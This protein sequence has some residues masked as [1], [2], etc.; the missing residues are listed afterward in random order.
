MAHRISRRFPIA[1]RH[2]EQ[3]ASEQRNDISDPQRQVD[4]PEGH[5]DIA[6]KD[7]EQSAQKEKDRGIEREENA[8]GAK[9][10]RDGV[11]HDGRMGSDNILRGEGS[12]LQAPRSKHQRSSKHRSSR[13][14][15][16]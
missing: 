6:R 14:Q 2:G 4:K 11:W 13:E 3:D 5:L 8:N 10:H 15:V 7:K 1:E 9:I 12:K 16:A